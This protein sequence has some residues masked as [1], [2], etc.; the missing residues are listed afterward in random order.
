MN[1]LATLLFSQGTP[2]ILAGDEFG[3]SQGGNNS[4]Y[5]QDNET[6]W[7]D[8][9]LADEDPAFLERVRQLIHLRRE[10]P[11]LRSSHYLHGESEIAWLTPDGE[12]MAARDWREARAFSLALGEGRLVVL[13]NGSDADAAFSI[14]SQDYEV[15]FSTVEN[16]DHSK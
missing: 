16:T 11:L 12:K 13:V 7:L 1:L 9:S 10:E 4:A 6:G 8:W 15:L 5:A 3:N 14:P 2:L